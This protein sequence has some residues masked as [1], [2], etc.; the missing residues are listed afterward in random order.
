MEL[1]E[2][3]ARYGFLIAYSMSVISTLGLIGITYLVVKQ[4]SVK[5]LK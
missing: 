1:T 3:L 4:D 5:K 2:D